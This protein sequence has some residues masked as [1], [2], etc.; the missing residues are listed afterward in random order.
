MDRFARLPDDRNRFTDSDRIKQPSLHIVP[1]GGV[2]EI[3]MNMMAYRYGDEIIVVD[4]GGLFP[5][6]SL[7]GIDLVVPDMHYL[8]ENAGLVKAVILTHGHEDHIGATPYFLRDFRVPVYGSRFTLELLRAKLEEHQDV[9]GS[10]A[11]EEVEAGDVIDFTHFKVEFL[12]VNHSVCDTL[13]LAIDTPEG[14]LVHTGD[15]RIDTTPFDGQVFD[16]QGFS[17][18]GDR[19]VLALLSD[20]TNIERSGFTRSE[21]DVKDELATLFETARGRLFVTLFSSSIPRIH[22][23]LEL[24]QR[25]GRK[26]HIAGKSLLTSTRIARNLSILRVPPD[27]LV[28]VGTLKSLPPEKVVVIL[29]GSQGEPRSVLSRVA[30]NDHKDIKVGPDDLVIFS[31]RGIPGHERAIDNIINHLYRQGAEVITERDRPIHTSGHGHAGELG[32]MLNL[33]RPE[34]FIPIHGEYRHL[35]KHGRLATEC[36]VDPARVIL[37]P[38]GTLLQFSEGMGEQV[39]K[40]STGRVYVDGKGFGDVGP[41]EIRERRKISE[42]GIIVV[43]LAISLQSG[44]ILTGPDLISR[45]FIFE[46]VSEQLFEQGRQVVLDALAEFNPESKSDLE[47][48]KEEIRIVLRR[49]FKKSLQRKPVVIPI[50]L[51]M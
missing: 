10:V 38:N 1:L 22:G 44:E 20:S 49:F 14:L 39:G 45:G 5:D 32:T 28:E 30:M 11:L 23:V 13:S 41:D 36:G 16:Y 29:T 6:S 31:A 18:L 33:T 40:V 50:L 26:V 43:L 15:F 2:G 51:G 7:L 37:A 21:Q 12:H 4:C 46:D 34:Y 25:F 24:A 47:E 42:T 27:L 17:R 9:V 19:G 8:K 48:V 3:G 35:I